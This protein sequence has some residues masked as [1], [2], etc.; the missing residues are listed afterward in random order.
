MK[1][2]YTDEELG[3]I[4]DRLKTVLMQHVGA[5]RK[6][7]MGELY[8]RVFCEGYQH[9]IND[10]RVLRKL[11]TE[12]RHEGIAICSK[13]SRSGGGYWLASAGSEL[14]DYCEDLKVEALK[15]LAIVSKLR[16]TT[17]PALIGQMQMNLTRSCE[18]EAKG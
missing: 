4:K 11:I 14:D 15:K 18:R 13:K 5:S 7:G 3:A 8:E 9:R 1:R 2:K 10:T 12:L 16:R 6:I 17:L